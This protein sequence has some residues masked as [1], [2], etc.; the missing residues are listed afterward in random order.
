MAEDDEAGAA[1]QFYALFDKHF[2]PAMRAQRRPEI[3]AAA[4]DHHPAFVKLG[5]C[6][7][8]RAASDASLFSRGDQRRDMAPVERRFCLREAQPD[9]G[10]E[11]VVR[12]ARPRRD[13]TAQVRT[14]FV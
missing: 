11:Q 12:V 13:F 1:Q 7:T 5:Q 3:G 6:I 2:A 4:A 14:L 9:Q 10:I 8:Q